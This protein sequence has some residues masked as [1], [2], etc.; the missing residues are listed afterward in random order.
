[1]AKEI[2]LKKLLRREDVAAVLT[3][4]SDG[5]DAVVDAKGRRLAGPLVDGPSVPVTRPDGT[6]LGTVTGPRAA[7]TA[8]VLTALAGNEQERRELADE[9]LD[10]YREVNL[11]YTLGEVLA[12]A[13]DRTD[14][15]A[16]ALREATRHVP[17]DQAYVVL[18]LDEPEVVASLDR[19]A[20]TRIPG[21]LTRARIESDDDGALLVAPLAFRGE[22][23]GAIVLRRRE[24]AFVAGD[25]KLIGAVAT[26]CAGVLERV[27]DEER[28]A[29]A[30][31]ERE[32]LL[33]RQ[34]DQ[35]RIELD[36]ELQAEEVVKVTETDYFGG[37]RAQASDLRRIIGDRPG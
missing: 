14:L 34:L 28:R 12:T 25:L 35:L 27:L 13:T 20:R 3:A 4:V 23:R 1:M 30:A 9:V 33:R 18:S 10:M 29:R 17:V 21:D 26:Q 36:H 31:A 19:N 7:A 37:L 6:L 11:L 5:Q 2:R 22:E 16:R 8:G 24:G 32:E 15:A